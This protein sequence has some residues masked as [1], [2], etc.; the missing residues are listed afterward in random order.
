MTGD[1]S[2][3]WDERYLVLKESFLMLVR[4]SDGS[5]SYVMLMDQ[6]FT[7]KRGMKETG[8]KEGLIV[9]VR[10]Y[11]RERGRRGKGRS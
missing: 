8:I 6:D 11:E 5:I 9:Q 10:F 3:R 1:F 7:V 2:L 4:P